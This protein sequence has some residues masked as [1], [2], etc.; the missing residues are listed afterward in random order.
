MRIVKFHFKYW[1]FHKIFQ[2]NKFFQKFQIWY[3]PEGSIYF[4]KSK[5]R[6]SLFV[7]EIIYWVNNILL[8][9][10]LCTSCFLDIFKQIVW[11]PFPTSRK[12]LLE[13]SCRGFESHLGQ[14]STATSNKSSVV[15]S[16]VCISSLRYSLVIT[17]ARFRWW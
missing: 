4:F 1:F 8:Q 5:N 15:L 16:T 14:I 10:I 17:C 6:C 12:Y 13:F 11:I 7:I 3:K 2:Y 9:L